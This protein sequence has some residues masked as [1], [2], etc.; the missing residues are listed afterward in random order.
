V[1]SVLITSLVAI[2]SRSA[3]ADPMQQGR[4]NSPLPVRCR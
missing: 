1:V 4:R 3:L 2:S